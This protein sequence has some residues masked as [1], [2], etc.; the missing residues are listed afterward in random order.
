MAPTMEAHRIGGG[1]KQILAVLHCMLPDVWT[2]NAPK[3]PCNP[4]RF[5]L[6]DRLYRRLLIGSL[7]QCGWLELQRKE[8][9][10]VHGCMASVVYRTDHCVYGCSN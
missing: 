8:E 4:V 9:Y 6:L 3:E 5:L 10:M 7:S 2:R 1:S